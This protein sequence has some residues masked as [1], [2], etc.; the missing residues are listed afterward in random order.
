MSDLNTYLHTSL[1]STSGSSTY[2]VKTP[3]K[4]SSHADPGFKTALGTTASLADQ[5]R[6][7]LTRYHRMIGVTP[8]RS[9]IKNTVTKL[10]GFYAQLKASGFDIKDVKTF[11]LRHAKALLQIWQS[12]ECAHG[13]VYMRWSMIRTWSRVLGKHGMIGPITDYQ[14]DFDRTNEP[15]TG[16]RSLNAD[17]VA[18]RS[19]FL[20]QKSDLTPYLVDRLTRELEL[21]R[22]MALQTDIDAVQSVVDGGDRV[23]R[24]GRGNHRK[25]VTQIQQHL[26]LMV[27]VLNFMRSRSRK[28]LAWTGL[29]IDTAVEKYAHRMTYVNRTLFPKNSD[30][31]LLTSQ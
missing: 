27:E 4:V 7:S 8:S 25:N 12:K 17:E 31:T 19:D 2:S 6:E 24:V 28:T 16:Y 29:D 3:Q 23:L 26:G 22:E 5:I 30:S 11:S 9:S 18:K 1:D 13:T 14:A 21:T 15:L 20:S 10:S